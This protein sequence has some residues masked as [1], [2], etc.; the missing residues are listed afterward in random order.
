MARVAFVTTSYP[1][2]PGDPAGHF[3]QTEARQRV[4]RGDAVTVLAP[5]DGVPP[6]DGVSVHWLPGSDAFGA[7]GALQRI[8]E[9]PWRA[10]DAARFALAARR[11]LRALGPLDEIVAHWLLPSALP[12]ALRCRCDVPLCV[13]VH[14][15]D[16]ALFERLPRPVRHCA[17]HAL[18]ARRARVRCVSEDLRERLVRA[19]PIL[20]PFCDVEP[21]AIDVSGVPTR[22]EARRALGVAGGERLALV[23]SRLVPAKRPEVAVRLALSR[24]PARVVVLGDGPLRRD[25][26]A[27]APC[28]QALGHRPRSEALAWI[29]AAD[30]LVSASRSEGAPTVIREARALGVPVLAVAAGDLRA[31]AKADAGI[32]L[33][34]D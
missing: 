13:V 30:L 11:A 33:V 17:A 21:A 8:R 19:A 7:P 4:A 32:E 28:V 10:A 5:G 24:S 27:L 9:R 20:A 2:A 1:R 23:V 29:A 22:A 15:T 34:D 25:V 14:G 12:I 6:T 26:A 31:W 3:V 16:G 18:A